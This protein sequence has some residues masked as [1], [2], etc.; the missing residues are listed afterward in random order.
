MDKV[1]I[2]NKIKDMTVDELKAYKREKQMER[3]RNLIQEKKEQIRETYNDKKKQER[4]NQE[5]G[6]RA[7]LKWIDK[8]RKREAEFK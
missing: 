1:E 5:S 3:I 2:K 7:G 4:F 8:D 6:Q